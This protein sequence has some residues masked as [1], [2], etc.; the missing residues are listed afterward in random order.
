MTNKKFVLV[1]ALALSFSLSILGVARVSHAG[2]SAAS[3]YFTDVQLV[4]QFGKPMRLYTDLLE[5]KIVIISTFFTRCQGSC[6]VING[7]LAVLRNAYTTRLD[8]DVHIISITNDPD[9]DTPQRIAEYARRFKAQAGWYFLSG[10]VDDVNFANYKL[11]QYVQEPAAHRDV[12]I[13]GNERS[14]LWKKI[15]GKAAIDAIKVSFDEVLND[16]N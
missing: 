6:P 8:K 14:G 10:S 12:I 15:N 4:N 11:G 13:M 7:K 5:N 2:E 9:Y 16:A 3:S 1:W